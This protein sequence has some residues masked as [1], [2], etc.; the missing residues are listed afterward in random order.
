[1]RILVKPISVSYLQPIANA[2]EV[3]ENASAPQ[4]TPGFI[5]VSREIHIAQANA[6]VGQHTPHYF[7][8]VGEGIVGSLLFLGVMLGPIP[9]SFIRIA[10]VLTSTP[11]LIALL[12][13][14]SLN[15]QKDK[16][17]RTTELDYVIHASMAPSFDALKVAADE[18]SRTHAVWNVLSS[19]PTANLKRNG[20]ARTTIDRQPARFTTRN[21]PFL[22]TGV[23]SL[24]FI[25]NDRWI[26]FLPDAVLVWQTGSYQAISYSRLHVSDS[27]LRFVETEK[28]PADSK[29][30]SYTWQFSNRDGGPD[31]RFKSNRQIPIVRYHQIVFSAPP[32][33]EFHAHIS[34]APAAQHFA[35]ALRDYVNALCVPLRQQADRSRQQRQPPPESY[36]APHSYNRQPP[37]G[38][39]PARQ[40]PQP[41]PPAGASTA[42]PWTVL[43]VLHNASLEEVEAAFRHLARRNHPDRVAGLDPEILALAEKRMKAINEAHTQIKRN[44]EGEP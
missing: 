17:A 24:S 10:L 16:V 27:E 4:E 26:T 37:L 14:V 15:I 38:P 22:A 30:V 3:S 8:I 29:V 7:L 2:A 39:R 35:A 40:P 18:L 12:I 25:V 19:R 13:Y 23:Q 20:A 42:D 34:N 41:P 31:L 9:S 6:R 43:G 1:M 21:P 28:I 44:F 11:L 32:D 33:F 36:S 5:E